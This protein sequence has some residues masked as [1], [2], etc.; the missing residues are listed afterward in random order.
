VHSARDTKS[1]FLEGREKKV[2]GKKLKKRFREG[3]GIKD[4]KIEKETKTK[5]KTKKKKKRGKGK[6]NGYRFDD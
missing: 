4:R 5:K 1:R 2:G 3:R 6:G